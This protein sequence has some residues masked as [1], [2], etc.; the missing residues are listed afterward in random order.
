MNATLAELLSDPEMRRCLAAL[1]GLEPTTLDTYAA[2]GTTLRATVSEPGT[3]S[4]AVSYAEPELTP[5]E[6]RMY[7]EL[8]AMMG[9]R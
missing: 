7:E 9:E 8:S 5:R 6:Q 4:P 2:R 3:G 1:T